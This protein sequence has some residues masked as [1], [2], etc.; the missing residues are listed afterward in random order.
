MAVLYRHIRLDSNQP[1]Y[2]GIGKTE[3]RAYDTHSRNKH[4][5]GIV[6][7]Y[8]YKVQIM[9]DDLTW[10]QACEKEREFIQLYGRKDLG[11]GTLVNLTDGGDGVIGVVF[12]E[13]HKAK[14]GAAL[15]GKPKSEEAKA[16]MCKPKSEEHVAKM[17]A[18]LKGRKLS[19][20]HKAKV[21]AA[22]T[23]RVL[24]EEWRAKIGAANAIREIKPETRAKLSAANKGKKHSAETNA[25]RVAT[26]RA[27]GNHW[28]SEETNAK[29]AAAQKG[30]KR[31]K[32][33]KKRME[34][35]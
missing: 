26:R 5:Q 34:N 2:I 31:G 11:L 21:S 7:K 10:E 29:R 23:G 25:K 13:E 6:N 3:K 16:N 28:C 15:I 32:Y 12:S 4:W 33:N 17:R 14:I 20:E 27:N 19:E 35:A 30:K 22:M 18:A 9:L 24:S 8:G 1:F